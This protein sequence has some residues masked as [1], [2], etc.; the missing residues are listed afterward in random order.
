MTSVSLPEIEIK[1][2]LMRR[3][4]MAKSLQIKRDYPE[5][6]EDP[7]QC[8][9]CF[10]KEACMVYHKTLEKGTEESSGV[11]DLFKE[12]TMHL[13]EKHVDYLSHWTK[14]LNLETM[15]NE[16]VRKQIWTKSM[17]K[18]IKRGQC[19]NYLFLKGITKEKDFKYLY[20]FEKYD[21]SNLFDD[22]KQKIPKQGEWM[23]LSSHDGRYGLATGGIIEINKTELTWSSRTKIETKLIGNVLYRLD[24]EEMLGSYKS[25]RNNLLTLFL[26]AGDIKRRQLVVELR[27]PLFRVDNK[28]HNCLYKKYAHEFSTLNANQQTAVKRILQAQDY[29]L[30]LGMPGTGKSTVIVFLIRILN[31]L[32]KKV[33]VTSYTNSAVDNIC[34]K[35]QKLEETNVETIRFL[36]VGNSKSIHPDVLK[37][38]PNTSNSVIH[39][40]ETVKNINIYFSTAI[41][42]PSNPIILKNKFDFC[43]VDEASQLTQPTILG[44]LQLCDVFVLVGDHYQ[45]PPLIQSD[46]AKKLGMDVSLF[47][48]L[49]DAHSDAVVELTHQYRMN[50]DIMSLANNLIYNHRLVCGSSEVQNTSLYVDKISGTNL[51][52]CW[53]KDVLNK[54]RKVIFY[55]VD[56]VT[57][58]TQEA[59][60]YCN[61]TEVSVCE[62]CVDVLN[63]HG[64]TGSQ[65]GIIAPYRAQLRLIRDT[66]GSKH[67]DVYID[68]IDR[69][70][71]LDKDCILMSFV[72]KKSSDTRSDNNEGKEGNS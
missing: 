53:W 37:N 21:H 48:R 62:K 46:E 9:R 6:L 2:L 1:S 40:Q 58:N 16:G 13:S 52:N 26:P 68:T 60:K 44:P 49:S 51:N 7:G 39:L 35:L 45:L 32:N 36:R 4:K 67:P 20:T 28:L 22:G 11:G 72:H 5:L 25:A 55:N 57:S 33:L 8:R 34:L 70:Q 63:K 17:D 15:E 24:V 23:V 19:I 41:S 12:L 3:N 56:G 43:I 50:E 31:Y 27:K 71:G 10:Q 14:L 54:D 61:E 38:M 64:V 66:V 47:K 42:A 59:S 30:V 18:R 69:Y 29:T 65:M